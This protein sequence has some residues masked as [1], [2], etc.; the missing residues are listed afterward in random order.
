MFKYSQA[1]Y[2]SFSEGAVSEDY[3][4]LTRMDRLNFNPEDYHCC[5]E[6]LYDTKNDK[7][8]EDFNQN[9]YVFPLRMAMLREKFPEVMESREDIENH[10]SYFIRFIIKDFLLN[11]IREFNPTLIMISYSGRLHIDDHHFVELLQEFTKIANYKLL[12]FPNLT[13]A[14]LS[15]EM[16]QT[17]DKDGEQCDY[18]NFIADPRIAAPLRS[19]DSSEEEWTDLFNKTARFLKVS[20]G[21]YNLNR[22]FE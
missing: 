13:S 15:E 5:T 12:F 9:I 16:A 7:T 11:Q 2:E 21:T 18:D 3:R 10:E 8:G 20:S 1:L 19:S 4:A 6:R 22:S 17:E 14:F